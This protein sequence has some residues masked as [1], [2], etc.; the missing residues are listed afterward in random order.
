[1]YNK[2]SQD[3]IAGALGLKAEEF[4]T[5]WASEDEVEL[6][7]AEGRFLTKDQEETLKDNHGKTRY[8]AGSEAAREMQLKDMSKLVG[9][10]ETIKNPQKFIDK[11]KERI[12]KEA[13]KKPNEKVTEL[14]T[15]LEKLRNTIKDKDT[16]YQ[17]LEGE[18]TTFKTRSSL[19]SHI[20]KLADIGLNND[21]VLDLFLKTHQI[22]DGTVLKDGVTL[23]DNLQ[24][25][26]KVAEVIGSFVKDKGWEFSENG[27]P[28]GRRNNPKP[29]SGT[30]GATYEDF[31]NEL[32]EKGYHPGGEEAE[33]LLKTYIKNNDK[34]LDD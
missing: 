1:M 29:K 24:N 31:E 13:N 23:K 27:D 21:D 26:L 5:G 34:F 25:N 20:P 17:T 32:K 15:D 4:A 22:K 12:L 2:E 10:E 8:D 3:L 9:F 16:A 28:K 19:I 6:K 7:L 18:V 11:F 33:A 30:D 14:E